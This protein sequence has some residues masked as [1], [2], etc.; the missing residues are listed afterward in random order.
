MKQT[1]KQ[2]PIYKKTLDLITETNKL[3]LEDK[4]FKRQLEQAIPAKFSIFEM[5]Q[6]TKHWV[7]TKYHAVVRGKPAFIACVDFNIYLSE[8]ALEDQRDSSKHWAWNKLV[9]KLRQGPNLARWGEGGVAF[10]SY[11]GLDEMGRG[12]EI[13]DD[14]FVEIKDLRRAG[15]KI[16]KYDWEK[17]NESKA[18]KQ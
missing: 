12:Y 18:K 14:I 8:S 3:C 10:V 11:E 5:P 15:M 17:D 2:K 4:N 7:E 6:Q 13:K 1:Q 9:E 16:K